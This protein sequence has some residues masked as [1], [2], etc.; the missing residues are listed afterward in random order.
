MRK[1]FKTVGTFFVILCAAL[2]AVALYAA[3]RSPVFGRGTAY[4]FY[5]GANSS[6]LAVQ[7]QTP[8]LT[9]F[10]IGET[11]GESVRYKGDLFEELKEKFRAELLFSETVCGITNYYLY[12]AALGEGVL[13]N[14]V[15]VNLHIA[16]NGTYTAAGT[17]LIFGGF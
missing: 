6:S 4:T 2:C 1:I 15:C 10:L 13:I 5:T 16:V 3:F 11:A 12:S 17:P 9:K 14:G 8:A 7:T